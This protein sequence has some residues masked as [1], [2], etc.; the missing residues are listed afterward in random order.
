MRVQWMNTN[1]EYARFKVGRGTYGDPKVLGEFATLEVGSFTSFAAEVLILLGGEHHTEWCTTGM[2]AHYL[3]AGDLRKRYAQNGAKGNV[4][5]GSDCWIGYRATILSGVTIGHGAVV[6]ACSVVT[7]DIEP[8]MIAAGNPARQIRGRF[9]GCGVENVY[10]RI[11][12]AAWWNRSDD[13]IREFLPLLMSDKI[14]E[15]LEKA[16]R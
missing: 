11:V 5:I 8:Y 9:D 10:D 16:E 14:E 2:V 7:R 3:S 13:W 4:V 6:G 1:P 15:F 12:K